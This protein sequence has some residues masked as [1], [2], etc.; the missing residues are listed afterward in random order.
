MSQLCLDPGEKARK[1]HS[2]VLQVLQNPGK[3]GALAVSM[4]VSDSAVSRLKT[5]HLEPVLHMLYRLGFKLVSSDMVCVAADELAF[6]KRTYVQQVA[7]EQE[8]SSLFG[9]L[10]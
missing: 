1:A 9:D 10:E 8:A 2:R 5:D 4:G 6:L 7:R 3:G